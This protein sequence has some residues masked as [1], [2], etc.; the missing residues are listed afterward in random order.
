MPDGEDKGTAPFEKRKMWETN[1]FFCHKYMCNSYHET[2]MY[3]NPK[4]GHLYCVMLSL[5]N[6]RSLLQTCYTNA[7]KLWLF[8]LEYTN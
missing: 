6:E 3:L 2:G 1:R 8:C 5:S 7:R 4:T